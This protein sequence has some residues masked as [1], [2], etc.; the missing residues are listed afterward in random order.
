MLT[1]RL[2]GFLFLLAAGREVFKAKR[3]GAEERNH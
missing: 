2:F 1:R 3:G